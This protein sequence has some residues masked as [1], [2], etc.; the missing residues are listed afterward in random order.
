[1]SA[2]P[3]ARYL[4][5]FDGLDDAASG[6]RLGSG[7]GA[8]ASKASV[9]DEAFA[10]GKAAAD[11]ELKAQLD[12]Q[13]ELHEKALG[14]ARETWAKQEGAKL[15]EQLSGGLAAIE[16]QVAGVAAR[17]LEPFIAAEMRTR[18]IADLAESLGVLLAQERS[19]AVSIS[20]APD[21]LGALRDRL[22]GK[23]ENVSYHPS[24]ACDVRVTVGQTVLET[25]LGAWMARIREA[26]T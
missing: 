24:E 11:A 2:V 25:R 15:A 10:K 17:I 6:A 21:L 16:C 13:V 19:A 8:P 22:E 1:M 4:L 18:A 5:E 20:G 3:I 12:R 26:V 23:V 14:S 7:R 9:I